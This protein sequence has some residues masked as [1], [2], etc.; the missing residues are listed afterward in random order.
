[1]LQEHIVYIILRKRGGGDRTIFHPSKFTKSLQYAIIE[2][3]L[4]ELPVHRSAAG[5]IRGI[6][7]PLLRNAERHSKFRYSVRIDFE[8]FFPSIC[9]NDLID[10]VKSSEK[11]KDI[12]GEDEQFLTKSLFVRY[13]TGHIGLAIG[14]PSSPIISNIIMFSLDEKISKL[15]ISTSMDSVYTRYADDIVFSTNDSGACRRFLDG[16]DDLVKNIKSPNLKI[17]TKKTVLTSRGTKRV[18]TGL[19]I[20]PNGEVSIGRKNKRYVRKLLLEFKNKRLDTERTKY[21]SGYLSFI[22]TL[23]PTSTID[24]L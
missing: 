5:Y 11:F 22:L 17:N 18:I 19:Y 14:A 12:S 16:V 3:I 9:P 8:D 15:A 13:P 6:K 20:C 1:M 4:R 24:L 7:S 10:I 23:S 21:L 2:T